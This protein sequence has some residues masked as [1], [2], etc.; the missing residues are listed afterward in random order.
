MTRS[1]GTFGSR[2]ADFWADLWQDGRGWVLVVVSAGWMLVL[3]GRIVYPALLP[4]ITAE[5]QID[6]A[7]AGLLVGVLWASYSL[8]Q[9]PGGVVADWAGERAVLTLSL[10]GSFV[11]MAAIFLAP[12]LGAF[13][14]ATAILGVG[15][16]LYG[17]TRV[18]VLS[19]TYPDMDN[20]A[21]SIN[22]A[23][24]NV[25]N[26]VLPILA[27]TVAAALGWRMGF[28]ILVPLFALT[29]VGVWFV[30]P[31]RTSPPTNEDESVRETMR[32]VAAAV[33]R[34]EVLMVTFVLFMLMFLYQSVTGFL[35]TYLVESKGLGADTAATLYGVFFASA[36]VF[37]FAVGPV[38]D[39]YGQRVALSVF[40]GLAVPAF[41][42]LPFASGLPQLVVVVVLLSATLGAFP[43]S[44]AY[45]VRA[46]PSD[47][48]GSGYGL[49]RTF[50]I[51]FGAAGPPT[52]GLLADAGLFDESFYLLGAV[53]VA[54]SV[55]SRLLPEVAPDS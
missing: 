25:S 16:G 35:T 49:L 37:Q 26:T 53:A 11:G 42:A 6:Y 50:Y 54:A 15:N 18:T 39:R 48:Q 43:P 38:A 20:T 46:I 33:K 36:T 22:Q 19:D 34:R 45:T 13:V 44:H 29:A 17:T 32:A 5:F 21:I 3:G 23:S 31:R 4:L 24:G 30:V 12:V 8:M 14:V 52:V 40:L 41:V 2:I 47:I 1:P 9:F 27:G 28:G 7:T 51:A 55:G 10:V